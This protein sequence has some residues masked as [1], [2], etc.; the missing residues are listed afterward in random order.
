MTVVSK[1]NA[2]IKYKE[3]NTVDE[4]DIGYTSGAYELDLAFSDETSSQYTISV[5]LGKPKY[6]YANKNVVFFPIY[7]VSKRVV[8]AQIGIFELESSKLLNVYKQGTIDVAKLSDPVLY[9]FLTP[10]YLAKINADPKLFSQESVSK[11][12]EEEEDPEEMLEPILDQDQADHLSL[13][14]KPTDLSKS[15]IASD[16]LVEE[17][18]FE[19][20]ETDTEIE[21]LQEDT[22]EISAKNKAEYTESARNTW[23]EKYMKNNHYRIHENEGSGDC[24]F[25][26]VR[27]AF[28]QIG[29]KTSVEKLRAKLSAEL[30]D[31]V[32]QEHRKIYLGFQDQITEVDKEMAQIKQTIAEYK[33][34]VKS[35]AEDTKALIRE[36]SALGEKYKTLAKNKTQTEGLRDEVVGYMNEIDTLEKMREY[37]KTSSF[38]ADTWTISTLERLLNVKF[39]ILSESAFS[40]SDLDGVIQ[41]G[42]LNNELQERQHFV[43]DYY[44]LTSFTGNHYRLISY[45]QKKIFAFREVP[46]DVKVLILNKC[47]AKTAGAFYLIQDFRNFKTKFGIDEDE[48][49]PDDYV[50]SPGAGDLF[51][52]NTIFVFY[53]RSDKAVKPGKG[54]GEKIPAEKT[55]DFATLGSKAQL[56]WR[57]KLDDEWVSPVFIDRKKW[58]SVEHFLL[59][60]K[61]KKGHPDIY[62]MF[63]LDSDSE[64]SKSVKDAK[65][66]KGL[67]PREDDENKKTKNR[68]RIIAPDLDFDSVRLAEEREKALRAKFLDNEDFKGILALTKRALLLKKNPTENTLDPDTQLMK[69]RLEI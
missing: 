4:E 54:D 56:D 60:S 18:L 52:P 57:K 65:A 36:V 25:A 3:I 43:P 13:K 67:K 34:R 12:R 11:S 41:C 16:K 44:I 20:G 47:L 27:D 33:K 64:L 6:I 66:F 59:A 38:W 31:D 32:F 46:Y 42:E 15:K 2:E 26:V 37:I 40:E 29:K 49:R 69:I 1:L 22:A 68:I 62:D 5:V 19:P 48:G 63:S 50:D 10:D 23:I 24:F 55:S 53:S 21:P 35:T 17:G 9:S 61:Y 28:A 14:T 8:R 58:S 30:T 39:V 45:K 51:D 7:A